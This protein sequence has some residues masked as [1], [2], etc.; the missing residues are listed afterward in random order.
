MPSIGFTISSLAEGSTGY[1]HRGNCE[2]WILVQNPGDTTAHIEITYITEDGPVPGPE[3][4]LAPGTRKSFNVADAVPGTWSVSTSIASDQPVIVERSMYWNTAG[5]V[6]R[7]AAHA[8]IGFN[9]ES[10]GE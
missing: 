5:G 1:E 8:S 10:V 9:P 4:T 7:Q 3:A 2:S 6:H